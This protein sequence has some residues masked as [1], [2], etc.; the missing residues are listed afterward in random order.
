MR[1]NDRRLLAQLVIVAVCLFSGAATSFHASAQPQQGKCPTTRVSCPDMV[2]AGEP[3]TITAN[4]SGGDPNVTPT[5]NWTVS[6][7]TISSGQGTSTIT[8]D[9]T[10]LTENSSVTATVELGGF[11]RECGYGS[12]VGSCTT[13]VMKKPEARKLN[14]YTTLKPAD[15]NVRLDNFFI[16]M[17]NDPTATAYVIA[18]GGRTG[19]VGDGQ[20]AADKAKA[21][22][23]NKRGLDG[24]R[25]TAVDGGLREQ[26]TTELWLAPSGAQPP[27]ATPTVDPSE[28]KPAKQTKPAAPK[29]TT[30]RKKS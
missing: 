12:T 14:E 10:S 18:Y 19:R 15:E 25:V 8:V 27:R 2:N 1:L 20:R 4:V 13:S 5:Y 7:G 24:Q 26:A 16:E 17:T 28:I 21:Y 30:P 29:K 9:T 11:D 22:L 23:V 3:L 6:A